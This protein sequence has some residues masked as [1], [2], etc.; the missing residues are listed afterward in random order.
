V[1]IEE[2]IRES[3]EA[4]YSSPGAEYQEFDS[5][6]WPR[7]RYEAVLKAVPV[8][9]RLLDVGC[10]DGQMLYTLRSKSKELFGL[11]LARNRIETAR[12]QLKRMG[13]AASIAEGNIERGVDFPD[14]FFDV[15]VCADTLQYVVDLWSATNEMVRLLN[16]RGCLVV[17]V[18]NV[19]SL[20][21][22][23]AVLCGRFPATSAAE[24]G[25]AIRPGALYDEGTL[26][27]FTFFTL[28]KLFRTS[29]IL[30]VRRLGYGRLGRPRNWWPALSSDGA[31]VVGV[32]RATRE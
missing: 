3:F 7:N 26:H 11:E 13:V 31:C 24:Q 20:R 9:G 10:G 6:R 12:S 14:G 18:P 28:E 2:P 29:G 17:T 21:R 5:E 23:L 22:R 30:P 4:I 1:A 27:Y 25:F 15:V 19:A 8:G 32:K 16:P